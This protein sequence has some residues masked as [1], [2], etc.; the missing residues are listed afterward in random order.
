[1]ATFNVIE[2]RE[3][4]T[5]QEFLKN[6]T[7]EFRPRLESGI[8]KLVIYFQDAYKDMIE[9]GHISMPHE[10]MSNKDNFK[11]HSLEKWIVD[12]AD[13]VIPSGVFKNN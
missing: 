5:V 3:Y 12:H 1:M 13:E 9:I 11:E 2:K 8:I 4:K 7:F 6:E 10:F